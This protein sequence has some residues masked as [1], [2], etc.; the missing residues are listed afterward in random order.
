MHDASYQCLDERQLEL[1][2][3]NTSLIWNLSI[4]HRRI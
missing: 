4:S 3:V 2:T 1:E